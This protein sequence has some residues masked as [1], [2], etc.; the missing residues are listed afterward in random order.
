MLSRILSVL[1]QCL[2]APGPLTLTSL[3]AASGL[4]KTTTWRIAESLVA[5]DLLLRSTEGYL[6]SNGVVK[7]GEQAAKH[8]LLRSIVLPELVELHHQTSAA[9]WAVDVRRDHD[10]VII[11]SVY[12]P[13]AVQNN[14]RDDWQ[15]DPRDPA[16][17]SSALGHVALADRHDLVDGLLQRGVPRLTR[18]SE[19]SPAQILRA[20]GQAHEDRE[21]IEHGKF[22]LGWSCL[23]VPITDRVSGLTVG[24]LGVVDRTPRFLERR[25]SRVA[26]LTATRIENQW[27]LSAVSRAP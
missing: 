11:A 3:S 8:N 13:S 7:R 5:Q 14:Y 16:I 23:A 22:W 26:H 9:V 18:Y 2:K 25:L 27:P 4:P 17:L 12:D 6:A 24:V 1:D 19:T 10:W 21:F 15:H 20:L